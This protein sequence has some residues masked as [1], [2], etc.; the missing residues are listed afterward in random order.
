M[1]LK[2]FFVKASLLHTHLEIQ[3][4]IANLDFKA[5]KFVLHCI[6]SMPTHLFSYLLFQL[7]VNPVQNYSPT[8]ADSSIWEHPC[9][10]TRPIF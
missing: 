5:I 6:S 9:W 8:C 3:S 4:K 1:N 7:Q 2:L 10:L